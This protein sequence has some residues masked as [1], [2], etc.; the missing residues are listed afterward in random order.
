[1]PFNLDSLAPYLTKLRLTGGLAGKMCYVLI[2]FCIAT[3]YIVGCVS[4]SMYAVWIAV[5][6]LAL[7]F[8]I[9]A[10]V[11]LGLL[12]LAHRSP[13]SA[14]MD[15]AEL[16]VRDQ[17]LLGMKNNP[18]FV[19]RAE[20]TVP[21]APLEISPSDIKALNQPEESSSASRGE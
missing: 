5:G 18:V 20:D 17:I 4:H 11:L 14:L 7:M 12:H 3:A 8:I 21:K 19:G 6:G 2:I 15:G 9:C 13:S 16:L 10:V 1:M